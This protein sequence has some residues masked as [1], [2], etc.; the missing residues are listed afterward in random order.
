MKNIKKAV[1]ILLVSSSISFAQV[2]VQNPQPEK[3]KAENTINLQIDEKELIIL[4]M[5]NLVE[6]IKKHK[7]NIMELKAENA[8]EKQKIQKLQKEITEIEKAINKLQEQIALR[9]QV[10]SQQI[11]K[12]IQNQKAIWEELLKLKKQKDTINTK[13]KIKKNKEI[14]KEGVLKITSNLRSEP[15][16]GNNVIGIAKKGE[17]VKILGSSKNGKW[18]KV[19]HKEKIGYIYKKLINLSSSPQGSQDNS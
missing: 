5:K 12:L 15:K 10:L 8:L 7:K 13:D 3:R 9:D 14:T 4:T 11:K 2:V 16:M 19:K 17:R 6:D 18:Y 1:S